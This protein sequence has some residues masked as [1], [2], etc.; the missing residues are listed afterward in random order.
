MINIYSDSSEFRTFRLYYRS[1]LW[2]PMTYYN[3]FSTVRRTM[4]TRRKQRSIWLYAKKKNFNFSGFLNSAATSKRIIIS[5]TLLFIYFFEFRINHDAR[6][7]RTV[8]FPRK[9]RTP[10][11]TEKDAPFFSFDMLEGRLAYPSLQWWVFL[12]FNFFFSNR[13]RR[14]CEMARVHTPRFAVFLQ[15]VHEVINVQC[16]PTCR[17][18]T[19]LL[20]NF[21]V[22][23]TI[24]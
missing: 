3:V 21:N 13:T 7:S 20:W 10:V 4:V 15:Y 17:I 24:P 2:L 5:V 14:K 16:I 6:F 12:K 18:G 8:Y 19:V 22:P 11:R 23:F 1:Q 9:T